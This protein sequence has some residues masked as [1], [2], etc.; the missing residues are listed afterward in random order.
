[1]KA[2]ALGYE[3][4][5]QPFALGTLQLLQINRTRVGGSHD[6]SNDLRTKVIALMAVE[7]VLADVELWGKQANRDLL[8]P[9]TVPFALVA[10]PWPSAPMGGHN[11]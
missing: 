11:P 4:A 7:R 10:P 8:H 3:I 6:S 5:N 2:C 9:L 1:L